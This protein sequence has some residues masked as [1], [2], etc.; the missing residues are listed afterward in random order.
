M[1]VWVSIEEIE[2]EAGLVDKVEADSLLLLTAVGA[3]GSELSVLL[4]NDARIAELNG[5]WR[6][7]DGPTDVL[8]FAQDDADLLGDLVISVD[9][10]RRQGEA[11]GHSLQTELRIL[12]VHGVLHLQGYDH[13]VD[14]VS[15]DR[16]A[17][18]ESEI[19][20]RLGWQGTGLIERVFAGS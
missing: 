3:E 12:L 9:T 10:A 13:E 7:V 14:Q 11:R 15:H 1:K 16:M 19:M 4:V 17:Q 18:R 6:A 2:G 8:S 5:Q 20:G